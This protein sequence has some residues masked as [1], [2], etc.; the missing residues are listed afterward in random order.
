VNGYN[1]PCLA[2]YGNALELGIV[3]PEDGGGGGEEVEEQQS[4]NAKI[5][6]H[7]S[8][9]QEFRPFMGH[10]ALSDGM[11]TPGFFGQRRNE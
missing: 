11:L 8:Q 5:N 4:S 10:G 2:G 9:S 3:N 7:T 1:R 6:G